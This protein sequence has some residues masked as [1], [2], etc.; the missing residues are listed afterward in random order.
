MRGVGDRRRAGHAL[1][2]ATPG[3]SATFV[4]GVVCYA[5]SVKRGLLGVT[6]ERVVSGECAEQLA[7]GLRG[8]ARGRLGVCR[9]PATAGPGR[10][11][12]RAGGHGLRRG[13]PAAE[14]RAAPGSTFVAARREDPGEPR[15]RLARLLLDGG[16][17]CLTTSSP[18]SP[19]RCT[20]GRRTTSPKRATWPPRRLE[21][22]ALA[23]EHQAAEEA[24]GRGVGSQPPG[25][26]SR[27][28]RSTPCSH[29]PSLFG[30]RPKPSTAT[31][32]AR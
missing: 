20:P 25:A 13:S 29:S 15:R 18:R 19:R 5:T 23:A 7:T 9:R 28:S 17:P 30:Q 26:G 24:L 21:D 3:A 22:K 12:E 27:A 16:L 4:G 8:P 31:S 6:A 10:Q 32:S 1:L 11:E 14:G 2:T